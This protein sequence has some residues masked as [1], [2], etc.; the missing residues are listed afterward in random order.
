MEREP[1]NER[2][3]RGRRKNFPFLHVFS[4]LS[5]LVYLP[6][7][8][9]GP[10]DNPQTAL[11]IFFFFFFVLL[12]FRYLTEVF[13]DNLKIQESVEKL[14]QITVPG[15][16]GWKKLAHKYKM[17]EETIGFLDEN[18]EG[19]KGVIDYLK[20]TYPELTGYDFCKDL[21][22]IG[23]NDIIKKLSDQLVSVAN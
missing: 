22:E 4:T 21:K 1:K 8:S 7:H 18:H 19:G 11:L 9:R 6:Q 12:G 20:S 14:L 23:R 5:P 13:R 16:G 3:G 10:L 15:A 17:T 2:A